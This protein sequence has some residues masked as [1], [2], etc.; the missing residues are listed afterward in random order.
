[1]PH[2]APTPD[3]SGARQPPGRVPPTAVATLSPLPPPVPPGRPR[4]GRRGGLLGMFQRL[5]GQALDVADALVARL[6]GGRSAGVLLLAA[7]L[8]LVPGQAGAQTARDSIL[9]TVQEF[10]RTMSARDSAGAAATLMPQGHFFSVAVR[11]DSAIIRHR[12]HAGYLA[13]LPSGR[14]ALQ[15]RMWEPTV[16]IHGPIAVVWTPYDFYVNGEFSHCGVDAF[17]LLRTPTGWKIADGAY[18]TERTGCPPSPLGPLRR[19]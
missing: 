19:P 17:T 13:T 12:P 9:A 11:G 5:A 10:F 4:V 16:M 7:S 14:E 1:M 3:P 6:T 15:E 18:T 8:A 2:P